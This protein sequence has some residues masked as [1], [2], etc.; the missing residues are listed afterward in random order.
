MNTTNENINQEM[1]RE[2]S[3]ALRNHNTK[4]KVQK[5]FNFLVESIHYKNTYFLKQFLQEFV[6]KVFDKDRQSFWAKLLFCK[7]NVYSR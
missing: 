4:V 7:I 1:K 6:R 5:S 3:Y 2:S